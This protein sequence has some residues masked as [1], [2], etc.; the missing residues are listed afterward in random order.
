MKLELTY[1]PIH[2][3]DVASGLPVLIVGFITDDKDPVNAMCVDSTGEPAY[4]PFDRL[5]LRV[6]WHY[7]FKK[8]KW[9]D[10]D[11]TE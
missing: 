9:I 8:E 10:E 11:D 3:E 6:K 7:E 5:S 2:A 1:P 4:I